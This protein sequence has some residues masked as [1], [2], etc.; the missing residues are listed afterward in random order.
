MK[1]LLEEVIEAWEDTRAGVIAEVENIPPKEFGF[2]PTEDNRSVS[3]LVVHIMEVGLM[4]SGELTREGGDFRRKPYDKLIDEYARS[5]QH[6]SS[7]R[8]LLAALRSTLRDGV[9]A[10]R[11]A[12]ELRML[13]LITRFDGNQ[14]TRLAW[15]N[16]GIAHEM[17]HRGQLALYQRHMGIMPALTKRISGTS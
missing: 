8:E 10:F 7:K 3:E 9:K 13:Q 1:S 2:R 14:G 15:F 12:G 16:H 17:Y 11:E 4:M 5:I 6:L